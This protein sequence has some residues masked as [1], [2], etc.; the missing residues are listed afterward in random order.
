MRLVLLVQHQLLVQHNQE[1]AQHAPRY[2][3]RHSA[4]ER[5]CD[6]APLWHLYG[7]DHT[8]AQESQTSIAVRAGGGGALTT[9]AQHSLLS[10]PLIRKHLA[11]LVLFSMVWGE[12][13][14]TVH[15]AGRKR[16]HPGLKALLLVLKLSHL[17]EGQRVAAAQ[18]RECE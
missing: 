6:G 14:A 9:G 3:H 17:L 11:A 16:S 8:G 13:T 2:Q 18:G 12:G 15:C 10:S 4:K 1:P 7:T 5:Q